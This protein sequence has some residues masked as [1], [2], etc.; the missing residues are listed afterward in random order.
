MAVH[1]VVKGLTAQPL[2]GPEH[3]LSIAAD[4]VRAV[5]LKPMRLGGAVRCMQ[6]AAAA[7]A[8]GIEPVVTHMM[9]GPIALAAARALAFA[10][11]PALACGLAAHD[12]LGSWPVPVHPHLRGAV[13]VPRR[14]P[15][16]GAAAT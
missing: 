13:A 10:L 3:D 9:D 6:I 5:V 2:F 1:R 8:V 11:Q 7:R 14:E 4:S 16:H 12:A 15:G